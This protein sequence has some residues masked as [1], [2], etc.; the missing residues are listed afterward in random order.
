VKLFSRSLKKINEFT[1]INQV[2]FVTKNAL[3]QI[4]KKYVTE[5]QTRLS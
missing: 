1:G 5:L 3:Y 2:N 4:S